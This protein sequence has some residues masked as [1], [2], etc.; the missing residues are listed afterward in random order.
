MRTVQPPTQ[1]ISS[2]LLDTTG[3]IGGRMMITKLMF[4]Y[5]A[6]PDELQPP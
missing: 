3:V 5:T 2:D 1:G 4:L 6:T